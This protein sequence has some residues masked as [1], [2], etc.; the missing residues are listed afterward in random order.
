MT[1]HG[2]RHASAGRGRRRRPAGRSPRPRAEPGVGAAII[3]GYRRALEERVD[4]TAVMAGD[5]QMD[6]D[7]LA[8]LV[9]PVARGDRY[10]KANRLITGRPGS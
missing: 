7:D 6:P 10:A 8:A 2:T 3:T 5:N 1:P 9:T 4:V